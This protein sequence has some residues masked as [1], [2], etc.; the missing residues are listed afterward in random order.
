MRK[1]Y[2]SSI[3]KLKQRQR[4]GDPRVSPL[5]TSSRCA[6]TLN[7]PRQANRYLH[8]WLSPSYFLG[9]GG[10]RQETVR[11]VSVLEEKE[12][13]GPRLAMLLVITL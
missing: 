8:M 7:Y 13:S 1:R 6:P 5:T 10:N 9:T 4:T 11:I 12:L 2:K 3:N